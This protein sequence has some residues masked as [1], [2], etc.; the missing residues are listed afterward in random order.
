MLCDYLEEWDAGARGC[1][2]R[3]SLK[4]GWGYIYIRRVDSCC[5]AA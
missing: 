1:S 3:G 2:L 5:C 4:R